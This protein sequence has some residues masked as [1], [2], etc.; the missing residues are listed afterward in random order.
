MN[1]LIYMWKEKTHYKLQLLL[2]P[3]TEFLYKLNTL[4]KRTIMIQKIFR[5]IRL[6]II[7]GCFSEILSQQVEFKNYRDLTS[8]RSVRESIETLRNNR[9]Y[10]PPNIVV[11]L[12]D[13][14]GYGDLSISGHPTSYTPNIDRLASAGKFFT[15]F[16]V[17]SPVCSPSR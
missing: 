3:S 11:M 1:V 12:A 9:L 13:D 7:F 17:T 6:T 5:I 15:Q 16:Y 4:S 8:T 10:Q 2:C 14:L